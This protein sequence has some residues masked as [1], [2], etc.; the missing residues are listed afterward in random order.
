M[1][2]RAGMY[3]WEYIC[4]TLSYILHWK[5]IRRYCSSFI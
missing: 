5:N 1:K 4:T 2:I 3:I